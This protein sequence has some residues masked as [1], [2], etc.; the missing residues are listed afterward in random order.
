M[1]VGNGDFSIV[2][3]LDVEVTYESCQCGDWPLFGKPV[4][5]LQWG[6]REG[7][8]LEENMLNKHKINASLSIPH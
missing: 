6:V 2:Q 4:S 5:G 1:K 8:S 3:V 7:E